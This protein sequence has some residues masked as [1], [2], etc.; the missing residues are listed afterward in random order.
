[1]EPTALS[2]ED[3]RASPLVG[4][5]RLVDM[6][7]LVRSSEDPNQVKFA[8]VLSGPDYQVDPP[9]VENEWMWARPVGDG[10]Y[11]VQ[12][13]PFFGKSF[14]RND[15]I[16]CCSSPSALDGSLVFDGVAYRGGHSTYRIR[17]E[18]EEQYINEDKYSIKFLLNLLFE[19]GCKFELG[20]LGL[21]AVDAGPSVR[22]GAVT[23][24]LNS[25][26]ELG[27]WDWEA[28][29]IDENNPNW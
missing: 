27:I 29:Y 14:S 7:G 21:I 25:G 11:E 10:S 5:M 20:A 1:M 26:L 13:I 15:H 19:G 24:I 23:Y 3:G 6:D 9:S 18:S 8:L 2:T 16:K 17:V 4:E 12:N 28:G 22:L